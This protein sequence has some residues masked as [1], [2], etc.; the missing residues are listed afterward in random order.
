M[1]WGKYLSDCFIVYQCGASPVM[2][3]RLWFIVFIAK[4]AFS[5]QTLVFSSA[6]YCYVFGHCNDVT[7]YRR[8]LTSIPYEHG[9]LVMHCSAIKI[10]TRQQSRLHENHIQPKLKALEFR[11]MCLRG[12]TSMLALPSALCTR[13]FD[14]VSIQ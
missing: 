7:K 3:A 9:M 14:Q 6:C 2:E 5:A 8:D 11:C 4:V 12:N 13:H 1:T 10:C